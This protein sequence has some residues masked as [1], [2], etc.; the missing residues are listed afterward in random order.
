MSPKPVSVV[1]IAWASFRNVL[2]SILRI[3]A[4]KNRMVKGVIS[5]VIHTCT[6]YLITTDLY[7]VLR[8]PA[9]KISHD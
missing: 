3:P 9:I 8:N 7:A 2:Y 5:C 6:L 1:F 4:I